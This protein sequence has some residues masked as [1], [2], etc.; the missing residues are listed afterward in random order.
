MGLFLGSQCPATAAPSPATTDT[1]PPLTLDRNDPALALALAD[2]ATLAAPK[3]LELDVTRLG[4]QQLIEN[5]QPDRRKDETAAPAPSAS[6]SAGQKPGREPGKA[7]SAPASPSPTASASLLPP[8]PSHKARPTATSSPAAAPAVGVPL[9]RTV[10]GAGAL[11]AALL[12]ALLALRLHRRR[13]RKTRTHLQASPL[14]QATDETG[15]VRA[16]MARLDTALRTLAHHHSAQHPGQAPPGIRAALLTTG[17]VQILPQDKRLAPLPPFTQ[18]PERWW[19]LPKEVILLD[20]DDARAVPAPY[21]GLVTLGTTTDG[22]LLLLNLAARPALL[23]EGSPDHVTQVCASLTLEAALSPWAADTEVW[24]IGFADDLPHALPG[25]PLTHLPHASPALRHLTERFLEIHQQPPDACRRPLLVCA[26]TLGSD[27]AQQLAHLIATSG[28]AAVTLIAPARTAAAYFP[29]ADILD[30]TL[31]GR[32]HLHSA[33]TDI[34][35]QRLTHADYRQI[36]HTLTDNPAQPDPPANGPHTNKQAQPQPTPR[37]APPAHPTGDGPTQSEP[38]ADEGTVFP[39]L[40]AATGQPPAGMQPQH[41]HSS[42]VRAHGHHPPPPQLKVLGPVDMDRVPTTGHGPRQAQLAALLYFRPG[43]HAASL[44]TD[45]DPTSPW[46]KRTLNARL[47]ELRRALG[48]DP[49]GH[50]YIPR[51]HHADDPYHLSPHITCD[52]THFRTL[53]DH[54][55]TQGP[56]ALT[57]LE[58]ALALVRGRPFGTHPLPWQEP[59]QQEMTTRIITVAHTIATHRTPP[60]PHH[61]LTKARQAITTALDTDHTAEILYHDWMR[62]EAAAHNRQGLHTALTRLQ[63]TNHTL[64]CPLEKETQDLINHL[65]HPTHPDPTPHH[66]PHHQ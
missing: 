27:S 34:T 41:D 65:L 2:G 39:A 20:E 11:L 21:P 58:T 10:L 47:Q 15:T 23:L 51:R 7:P 64:N 17:H 18:G 29:T 44:C 8:A 33:D 12:T 14:V 5:R 19:A 22:G 28:Q 1:S 24:V 57:D 55:L 50:P 45:M 35:L 36:I 66:P 4:I 9:L 6:A 59:H 48:Q 26:P 25:H 42:A 40:L 56:T 60:G 37:P 61:H 31:S 62:I 53:T 3:I 13:S 30:A 38:P 63:H 52:W 46:T 16:D 32:Q 54:A 49:D 43:R